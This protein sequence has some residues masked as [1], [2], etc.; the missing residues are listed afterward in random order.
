MSEPASSPDTPRFDPAR[1]R[2]VTFA[3][4][5]IS[6]T[7]ALEGTVVS[8]AMPTI[9]GDLQGLSLYSW[10]FSV[11]LLTST[12]TMPLYGRLADIYGRRRVLLLS[13]S[14]FLIGGLACAF[15]RPMPQ[16]VAARGLPGLGAAG[17][18]HVGIPGPPHPY[19]LR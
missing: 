5:L 2:A 6:A 14:L 11:F 19:S 13:T 15:A 9:V 18:P 16:L 7:A 8:T 12:V 1:R 10:V 3:L 4:A 17:L